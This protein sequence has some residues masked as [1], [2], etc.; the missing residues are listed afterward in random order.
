M[1][2]IDRISLMRTFVRIVESGNLSAAALQLGTSQPTISRRLRSLE[3]LLGVELLLRSTHA[4]KLTDD[5]ERCYTRAKAVIEAWSSL[6]EDIKGA[7][8]EPFGTLRVKAPHAFGQ[9]QLIGPLSAF[10]KKYPQINVNW[11]L[12][13]QPPDFISDNLDCAIHVGGVTE[14]SHVCVLLVEIPRI[15]VASPDLL[16]NHPDMSDVA[17]MAALPWI[18]LDTFYRHEV[19]L[20]HGQTAKT[21]RF[22]ISPRLISSSLFAVRGGALNG[23]GAAIVSSW[24]VQ[25]DIRSG[26]LVNLF[27]EWQANALPVYLVYPYAT[28]YPARLRKFLDVMRD[29]MPGIVGV[30]RPTGKNPAV[31]ANHEA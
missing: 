27:P 5:G 31:S 13:D 29:C 11:V 21:C 7:S 20:H 18:S 22:P 19:A 26:R 25:D 23:V 12:N 10:L 15:V 6:E 14:P 28:Y 4:I 2:I 24:I 17:D 16:Q 3:S 30:E 1:A 8:A 9:D